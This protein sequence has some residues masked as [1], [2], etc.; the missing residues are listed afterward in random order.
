MGEGEEERRGREMMGEDQ[1][2][3][4][5]CTGGPKAEGGN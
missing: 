1:C 3:S 2:L 5:I 4:E